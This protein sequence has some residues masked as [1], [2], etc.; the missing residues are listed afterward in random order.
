MVFFFASLFSVAL[1]D[2]KYTWYETDLVILI[3][4]AGPGTRG[5]Q[6]ALECRTAYC[7]DG[8]Q[9]MMKHAL[10]LKK[11]SQCKVIND[12]ANAIGVNWECSGR[13]HCNQGGYCECFEGYTEE[14]CSTQTAIV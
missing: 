13:G 12:Y 4:Y 5:D 1:L 3:T 14:Y 2:Q 8:C 11:N 10:D 9:P 7:G 6:F